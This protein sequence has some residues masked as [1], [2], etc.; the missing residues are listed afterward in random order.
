MS[1]IFRKASL[2]RLS[3]PEE[4]DQVITISVSGAWAALSA[5]LL[6]C[7]AASIW[8]VKGRLPTTAIGSGMIVSTGGVLTVVSRGGGI[9]RSVDVAVGQHVAANQVVATI[10]QPALVDRVQSM[11]AELNEMLRKHAGDRKLKAEEAKIRMEALARQRANVERSII[12]LREQARLAAERVPATEQLFAKGLVTN[13]QVIAARERVVELNGNVEDRLAQLKQLESQAFDLRTQPTTF[14][15][16]ARLEIANRQ[17]QIAQ[18]S[19]EQTLQETVTTPY[20]GEVVEVK[21]TPGAAVAAGIPV[22]SVQPDSDRLEA[23]TYVSSLQAKDIR[24]GMD[25][26]IS[27]SQ[28]KREEHGFMLGKVIFVADY[29]ATAAAVQRNFQNDQIVQTLTSHG[30][31]TEVRVVL[32]RAPNTVSGFRWSSS[33]GPPV[34]ISAGTIASSEIVTQWRAPITLVVPILRQTLGL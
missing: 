17:R 29:P 20:A 30:P 16:A 2:E 8:A 14:D 9:V 18:A 13:Q 12:E 21:V 28:V 25:A 32:D 22:L 7:A 27:P 6:F 33:Q 4:L 24:V 15:A 1:E 23:L 5:V 31:V 26:R 11:R 19:S 10:A 3:S 34:R